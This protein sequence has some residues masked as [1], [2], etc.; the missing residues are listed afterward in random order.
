MTDD[1]SN[2]NL[3]LLVP[4]DLPTDLNLD[5]QEKEVVT[6]ALTQLFLSLEQEEE[7]PKYC[8]GETI[9]LIDQAIATLGKGHQAIPNISKEKLSLKQWEIADYDRYFNIQ[10]I[11]SDTPAICITRSLLLT[12]RQFLYLCLQ[13]PTLAPAQ[14]IQQ[15]QGFEAIAHLLIR[16]FNL[17]L[18]SKS[19]PYPPQSPL[20]K[21]G[22]SD[23][24]PC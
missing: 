9:S 12:Y 11:E 18:N 8:L 10:H 5:T 2:L 7:R 3:D 16:I 23:P 14:L 19:R 22:N 13:N 1:L 15:R 17:E 21:G 4:W 24:P 20:A 6:Y